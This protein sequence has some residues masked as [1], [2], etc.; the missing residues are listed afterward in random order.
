MSEPERDVEVCEFCRTDQ[1]RELERQIRDAVEA[2]QVL[3]VVY[4]EARCERD[5]ARAEVERLRVAAEAARAWF[6]LKH[7]RDFHRDLTELEA[8]VWDKGPLGMA[9]L[10]DAALAAEEA[11]DG[12]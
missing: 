4:A 9:E 3:G 7:E 1:V 6:W 2:Q 10:L 11:P 12:H 8:S 5:E